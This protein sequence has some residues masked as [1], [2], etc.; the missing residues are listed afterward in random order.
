MGQQGIDGNGTL[1]QQVKPAR[2]LGVSPGL[3][4]CPRVFPSGLFL[5]SRRV[6]FPGVFRLHVQARART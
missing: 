1:S 4:L 2:G 5:L 6:G 3:H